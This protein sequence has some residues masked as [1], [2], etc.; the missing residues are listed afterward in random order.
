M[1]HS[2]H[3]FTPVALLSLPKTASVGDLFAAIEASVKPYVRAER[4]RGRERS[5]REEGALLLR[6]RASEPAVGGRPPEPPLLHLCSAAHVLGADPHIPPHPNPC[7][8]L[9]RARA[10]TRRRR[11]R[12]AS[13][14]RWP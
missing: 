7:C 9:A 13:C 8:M 14:A 4:V 5:E 12:P 11:A 3:S 6:E 2:P 1:Y 10:G